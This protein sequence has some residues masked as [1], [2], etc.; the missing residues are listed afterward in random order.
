MQ[1]I[2]SRTCKNLHAVWAHCVVKN[3]ARLA[4]HRA[5]GSARF[6][7]F[8]GQQC[9]TVDLIA[10][11]RRHA[12]AIREFGREQ[13]SARPWMYGRHGQLETEDFMFDK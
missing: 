12:Q 13:Q 2:P 3:G 1:A 6:M 9:N 8:A 5:L 7:I 4:V 11:T 10:Q